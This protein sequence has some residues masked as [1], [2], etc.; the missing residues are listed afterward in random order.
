KSVDVERL[1]SGRLAGGIEPDLL[2]PSLGLAQQVLAAALER[3]A[4]LVDGDRFFE[5]HLA[6]FEALDD[7][8][9]L[10]DRPLEG[11]ALDVGMSVVGHVRVPLSRTLYAESHSI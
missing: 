10:L 3:L 6:L 11:Q 8:L 1:G 4:A 7:G 2:Y 9:E 5:R